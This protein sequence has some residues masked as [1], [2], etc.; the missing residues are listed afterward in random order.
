MTTW[1]DILSE[2]NV[3]KSE[4]ERV[5]KCLLATRNRPVKKDTFDSHLT[6]YIEEYNKIIDLIN[7]YYNFLSNEHKKVACDFHTSLRDKVIKLFSVLSIRIA[8]SSNFRRIDPSVLNV[9]SDSDF[10][11]EMPMSADEFWALT[12]KTLNKN[13]S[14]DPLGLKSFLNAL[15][16]LRTKAGTDHQDLLRE[17]VLTKIDGN[18]LEFIPDNHHHLAN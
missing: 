2:V 11:F 18:A 4:F 15:R 17:I 9:D 16:L 7:K 13:Y 5:H 1:D 8:V 6:N 14:G 10:D 12:A 3:I